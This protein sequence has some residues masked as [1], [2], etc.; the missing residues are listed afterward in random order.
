M[1]NVG[2]PK[3]SLPPPPLRDTPGPSTKPGPL[4]SCSL[5]PVPNRRKDQNICNVHQDKQQSKILK[6]MLSERRF[7]GPIFIHAP[8]TPEKT[9]LGVG[10]YKKG[11]RIKFLPRGASKY[12]PPPPSPENALRPEMGVGGSYIIS[13]WTLV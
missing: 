11:G 8:P 7:T 3:R 2:H 9:L 13:P 12:T 6:A 4:G 1:R 5:F 10:V